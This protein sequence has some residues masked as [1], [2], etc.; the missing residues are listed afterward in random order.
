MGLENR[1]NTSN[2]MWEGGKETI[3]NR[4]ISLC[5]SYGR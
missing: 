5:C 4:V 1:G 3:N 2:T